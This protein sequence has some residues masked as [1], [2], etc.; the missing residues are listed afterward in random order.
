MADNSKRKTWKGC[1]TS[2]EEKSSSPADKKLK[3]NIFLTEFEAFSE[4]HE[5][6]SGVNMA[7]SARFCRSL[8]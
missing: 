6:L 4:T 2:S 1:S 8:N 7:D 5:A 3:F